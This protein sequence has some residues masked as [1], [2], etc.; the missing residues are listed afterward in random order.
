M[1]RSIPDGDGMS[2][3]YVGLASVAAGTLLY[4]VALT[5]LFSI[6]HGYHFAFLAISIGLLGFGASGTALALRRRP[7]TPPRPAPT[8]RLAV[9]AALALLAGYLAAN[10]VPFDPYR[11]AWEPE[12]F[13]L[14]AAYLLSLAA[15]FL[16]VGLVLALPLIGWP[17]RAGALYGATLVGS[18]V[19]SLLALVVLDRGAA[20]KAVLVAAAL[21]AGGGLALAAAGRDGRLARAEGL[22][23][24]AVVALCAALAASSPSWL[25]VRLS[26]YKPLSQLLNLPDARVLDGGSNALSRV[27]VV[28][29]SSIRSAPGLSLQYQ[30]PLPRQTAVVVDGEVVYTL[31]SRR[32]LPPGFL[33]SL[34]TSLPYRLRPAARV[35]I[36]EPGGGLDVLVALAGGARSVTAVEKNPLLADLLRSPLLS[37]AGGA[38]A[39]PRVRLVV[40]TPR[41]YLA[42]ADE[43]FDLIVLSLSENFR[44]VTAGAFSLSE[45]YGM[46]REAFRA[47]LDHL[48]RD[49]LLVVHRWLQL[50]PTE[51]LRAAATAVSALTDMGERPDTRLVAIRSF[52][53]MLVLAKREP[54][55][56]R[57]LREV[58]QFAETRR[59]DLVYYPGMR[60]SEANR[61]NVLQSD[62]YHESFR[63]LLADPRGFYDRYEYDVRP[64][65][66]DRPFFFHFFKWQQTGT[67]LA[68]LGKT[69]QPF[70]GSGYLILLALLMVVAVLSV[71]LVVVPVAAIRRRHRR[72]LAESG[73]WARPVVYF[74]GLGL[75]FLLVEVALI[76]RSIAFLDHPAQAFSVVLFGLLV[77]SGVGS[78]LSARLRWRPALAALAVAIAAY[79]WLLPRAVSA[80]L[81]S[82]LPVRLLVTLALLA[83]LG[84]LMGVPFPRGLRA[85]GETGPSWVPLAWG[86]NGFASVASAVLAALIALSW[87]FTVVFLSAALA[88]LLALAAVWRRDG[89]SPAALAGAGRTAHP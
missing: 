89:V 67:V 25:D 45:S 22:A 46:T 33:D 53:T 21:A 79:P 84:L 87:G 27:D 78:M 26:P 54:F 8:A 57:E 41:R 19:G 64:P 80:F 66:D 29:A 76:Q 30:G 2:F 61:F 51:E 71:A 3:V 14:L 62:P 77:S 52:S 59:F 63:A 65:E 85:L 16:L 58:K 73:G 18:G 47:S 23:A 7:P 69:W 72:G 17:A 70:G 20:P 28:E 24:A 82:G 40:S 4:E 86:V 39:D 74:S 42:G 10:R 81:A 68:L 31:T 55:D 50:P 32:S 15:P 43:R 49:G 13:A 34:P 60:P 38:Y 37:R 6:A 35:L 36:L 1:G 83:P 9:G 56:G 5:R 75:G 11:V 44:P 88:Y 12:Q 48:A